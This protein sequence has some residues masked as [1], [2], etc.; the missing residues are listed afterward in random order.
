MR[1]LL[2]LGLGPGCIGLSP[3]SGDKAVTADT[4]AVSAGPFTVSPGTIDFGTL[5]IGDE[6]AQEVAVTNTSDGLLRVTAAIDGD[7]AFSLTESSFA[8]AP[9]E[10]TV[11][12][13]A[14]SPS[15]GENYSGTLNLVD[16]DANTAPVS[17]TGACHWLERWPSS[18]RSPTVR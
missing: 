9:D 14:F 18:G 15:A 4:T 7:G 17:L 2:L 8:M 6:D 13:V 3:A 16:A 1:V 10:G 11:L 5:A 12:T